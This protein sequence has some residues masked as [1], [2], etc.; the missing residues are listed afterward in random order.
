M[1]NKKG[2]FVKGYKHTK[3]WKLEQSKRMKKY[4]KLGFIRSYRHTNETKNKISLN[5]AK[6][7]KDKKRPNISGENHPRWKKDRTKL[8]RYTKQGE[9]RTSAY[10]YW[11]KKV[12]ERDQYTCRINNKNCNGKITAHHILPWREFI[13]ERYNINNGITLCHA[14]HPR[15]RAKEQLL[16]PTFQELISQMN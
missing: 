4:R 13:E 10:F 8:C 7:W 14:H 1:R 3:E 15:G 16:V 5:N 2:Q 11:R 6:Y 12:W 9:R